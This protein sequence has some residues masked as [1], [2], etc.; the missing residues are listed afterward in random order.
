M[1]NDRSFAAS[2]IA[3]QRV[4]SAREDAKWLTIADVDWID[5]EYFLGKARRLK[6]KESFETSIRVLQALYKQ[7]LE[8]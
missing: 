5:L 8:R 7:V 3:A 2:E 6:D 4:S 1:N